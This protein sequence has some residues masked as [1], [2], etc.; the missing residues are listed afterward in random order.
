[1][2]KQH[3]DIPALYQPHGRYRYTYGV[4]WRALVAL[5]VSIVPCLPGLAY[6]VNPNVEIGGAAYLIQ[7]NWYYG[8]VVAF[9][10]YTMASLMFPASETLVPSMIETIDEGAVERLEAEKGLEVVSARERLDEQ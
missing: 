6:N 8:F 1:M 4:N 3:L 5:A 2:K 7:F 9:G 10:S